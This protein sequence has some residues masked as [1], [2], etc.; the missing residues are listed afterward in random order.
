MSSPSA[1]A[2]AGAGARGVLAATCVRCVGLAEGFMR[3][4]AWAEAAAA[5]LVALRRLEPRLIL[6]DGL[7]VA[8]MT[9]AEDVAA[10]LV[11][12]AEGLCYCLAQHCGPLAAPALAVAE[13]TKALEAVPAS[14][15]SAMKVAAAPLLF[16]IGE[17]HRAAGSPV[18]VAAG[19]F[20]R[21][22]GLDPGLSRAVAALEQ[23]RAQQAGQGGGGGGVAAGAAADAAA[24]SVGKPSGGGQQPSWLRAGSKA[25]AE[26][27]RQ[28]WAAMRRRQA[29]S[30]VRNEKAEAELWK[31]RQREREEAEIKRKADE[32]AADVRARKRQRQ[33]QAEEEGGG[34]GA[35]GR[36]R[37]GCGYRPAGGGH[38]KT[39][40]HDSS[41]AFRTLGL[42][43][44]GKQEPGAAEVRKAYRLMARKHHPDKNP[45]DVPGATARFQAIEEAFS[46][47]TG[48]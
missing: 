35:A 18:D 37:P 9:D 32:A 24:A 17:L 20:Q 44:V 40:R 29:V 2:S 11:Q 38:P 19:C 22:V 43:V 27:Q 34:G 30:T 42:T 33:R 1:G 10:L 31:K 3:R 39:G 12:T 23:L 16:E 47:L 28:K 48:G 25:A 46:I 14:F 7:P 15:A 8:T 26:E 41:W 5:F 4:G 36:P 21:A 45:A 13:Y 6:A